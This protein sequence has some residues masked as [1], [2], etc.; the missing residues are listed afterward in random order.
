MIEP[1]SG[2]VVRDIYVCLFSRPYLSFGVAVQ[3]D[4]ITLISYSDRLVWESNGGFWKMAYT[5]RRK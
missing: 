1:V 5:Y 4:V 3:N 2:R